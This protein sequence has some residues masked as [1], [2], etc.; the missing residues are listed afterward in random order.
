MK[1]LTK[2]QRYEMIKLLLILGVTAVLLPN[3]DYKDWRDNN[4]L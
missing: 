4:D 3:D 2:K 1:K